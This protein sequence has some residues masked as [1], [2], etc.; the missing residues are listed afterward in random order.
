MNQV[1]IALV[2]LGCDK[3]LVD[4]QVMI[5][6]CEKAGFTVVAEEAEA[7]I[8][9]VNTCC[10]IQDA[11]E[12]SIQAVLQAAD[13]KKNGTCKGVIVTGCLAQ[14][15]EKELLEEIPEADMILG[16]TAYEK[17]VEAAEKLLEGNRH[18]KYLESIDLPMEEENSI[19]RVSSHRGH[20]A[21]LKI[22]EGCDNHCTYCVIP[23]LRGKYRS[24]SLES[25]V[26]EAKELANMGARELVLVAQDTAAYG[27]DRYHQPMLHVLL[28]QLCQIEALSWIRLLYCYPEHVTQELIDT[29]QA[30]PKVCHY[31]DIPIQHGVDSVLTRMGRNTTGKEIK[32]KVDALR[33]AMPDIAIRTTMICGFPGETEEE[34]QELLDFIAEMRFERLGVFAY[35]QEEGTPAAKLPG[36]VSKRVKQNRK[37]TIMQLQQRISEE[38]NK[39]WIGQ[40]LEVIVEGSMP[41]EG[42]LCTRSFRDAPEIDGLVFIETQETFLSGDFLTVEITS[43]KEYDLIGRMV[44]TNESAK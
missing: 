18:V 12:E 15:Y 30:E 6:L 3:N 17:I 5:G 35:S 43:A 34:F 19:L 14:R 22:S 25:L 44:Q 2:S 20:T 11:L 26:L 36:Q 1:K 38:R 16:T 42:V 13:Y 28:Q 4:S 8:I 39:E 32:A 23:K 10:F 41:E 29:M 9:V 37:D 21:Y 7:D 40:R 27:T 31:I 24:R 33:T